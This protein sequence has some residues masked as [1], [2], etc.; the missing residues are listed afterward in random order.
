MKLNETKKIETNLYELN[1]TVDG[2]EYKKALDASYKKN[3]AK[4]TVPGFRKGKAPKGRV[5]QL[6]GEEYFYE[7]A[8]NDTY[9]A[10]YEAAVAE[11]GLEAVARPEVELKEANSEAYT[12]IAKVT[13]KPEVTLGE[14]KGLKVEREN[15]TI[16]DGD[17][18]VELNNM[19]DRNSRMVEVADG[20]AAKMGDTATIDYE[21]FVGEVA[22]EGGKGEDHP[23]SLGSGQFIPGFEEGVVGHKVG[24]SFDVNVTFPAE[25][26][27]EELAGKDATFKVTI[28]GLKRR[29]LPEIDDEFAKDVSEFDTLEELKKDLAE[30]LQKDKAEMM[31]GK[32]E[33]D[34]LE[35]AVKNMKAEIPTVMFEN[36][37]LD[38]IDDFGY[39][40][41]SQGMNLD[42]YMQY[43]GTTMEALKAQFMPQAETQVRTSL[44]LE[45]IAKVE[46]LEIT[47][48]EI[49][50][51]YERMAKDYE[52]ELEKVKSIVPVEEVRK[53]LTMGKAVDVIKD[54]AVISQ[55]K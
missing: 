31:D 44:L 30:K 11:A 49:N 16:T 19:A 24:E 1:I 43:T 13:V 5:L 2:E 23:L 4:I 7:D 48:E 52:M 41:Q 34:L 29:E 32:L 14:Y 18:Q 33:N 26:H 10:A 6:V 20:S 22:F 53:S 42:M 3:S 45:E 55:K 35:M 9:G 21:G 36:K 15:D 25:Y 8:I 39:R 47:E 17:V 37:A 40:L 51:E 27:S 38:M 46:K 50:A 54:S 28:K 12:F